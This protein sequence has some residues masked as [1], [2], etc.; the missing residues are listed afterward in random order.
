[1]NTEGQ[2][3]L[4][5]TEPQPIVEQAPEIQ[6]EPQAQAPVESHGAAHPVI[7]TL[8][9]RA[10]EPVADAADRFQRACGQADEI[11]PDLEF[12]Q[13]AIHVEEQCAGIVQQGRWRAA[14]W[15][16]VGHAGIVA[17]RG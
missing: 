4:V 11:R 10:V 1:M 17:V 9:Q 12:E 15:N 8:F 14:K 3:E 16:R 5:A 6:P 7:T 13:G 2:T